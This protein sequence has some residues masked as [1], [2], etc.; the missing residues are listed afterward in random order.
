MG[1]MILG[2]ITWYPAPSIKADS[3]M[4]LG[5]LIKRPEKTMELK[6]MVKAIYEMISPRWVSIRYRA[7]SFPPNAGSDKPG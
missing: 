1:A 3:S 5:M 4:D 7:E 6:A 2:S